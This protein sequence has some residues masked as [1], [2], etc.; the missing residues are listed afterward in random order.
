MG[1]YYD[2]AKLIPAQF[3]ET[4]LL[5]NYIW[6]AIAKEEDPDMIRLFI[7]YKNYIEPNNEQ[8]QYRD[9]R[10][11]NACKLCLTNILDKFKLLEPY[12]IQLERES[13]LIE[14]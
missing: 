2:I 9:G 5:D 3:R 1:G 6:K 8:Y 13:K 10:I 14:A 7:F 12:L 11:V 4:I